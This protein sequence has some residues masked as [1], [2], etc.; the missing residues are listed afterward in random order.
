MEDRKLKEYFKFD[1][2]DLEANRRGEF[3][4]KQRARLIEN[5]KKIQRRWGWRSV[6]LFLIAGIGPVAA[7]SAGDF[8]GWG[9]KI[10]WGFVWTGLWGGIG[11]VMLL[12][13]LSKPKPLA[14]AK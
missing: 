9:W 6:P 12:S 1:E 11:L 13:F 10:M 14:L 2:A 7:F 4:E 3:S 5:D 8:F